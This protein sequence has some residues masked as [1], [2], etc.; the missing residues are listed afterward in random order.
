MIENS[1]STIKKKRGIRIKQWP[2]HLL[3]IP[4]ILLAI[5]FYYVPMAGNIIAFQN[6]VPA[7]GLFG[8]Q[9]WVGL[10]N[11]KFL[12]I[13][14]D[15]FLVI[16]NTVLIASLKIIFGALIPICI[17]LM[18]NEVRQKLL[19]RS[20]QTLIY[21]PYF[22]SWVIFGGILMDLMSPSEGI[23]NKL[24]MML[25]FTPVY[26][27]GEPVI[28]PFVMVATDIWKTFGF[29]TIIY[30]AAITSI[31]P[32]LYEAASIDGAKR[33]QRVWHI[34]LSGIKP[35]IILLATLSLG[36]I[37]NAGFEQI[38]TMYNPLVYSTGDIIDTFVYRMAMK[39]AQYSLATAVGL[40]KSVISFILISLSYY[41]AVRFAD[42]TIF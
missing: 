42:Y 20:I 41:L 5:V 30:L 29:S 15:S 1:I 37:L 40:F 14:P 7:K 28:F 9:K 33:L 11:F 18:L 27:L 23:I 17:S 36:S 39:N 3:L 10:D 31:D 34:T 24:I 12:F 13:L 25:G 38:L 6:F 19:K 26:F 8:E 4:S 21:L 32:S 16:R 35:T 2:L 22:L